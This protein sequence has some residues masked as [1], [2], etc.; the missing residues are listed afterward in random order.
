MGVTR[1]NELLGARRGKRRHS[2]V[3]EGRRG[4]GEE[5]TWRRTFEGKMD[6]V[7]P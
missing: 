3:Q 1:G 5:D 7:G 4:K 6:E 2:G